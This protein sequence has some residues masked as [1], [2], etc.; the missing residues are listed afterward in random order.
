MIGGPGNRNWS[1]LNQFFGGPKSVRTAFQGSHLVEKTRPKTRGGGKALGFLS[2]G[3]AL[4]RG[5]TRARNDTITSVY[6]GGRSI[7]KEEDSSAGYKKREIIHHGVGN[8]G[9]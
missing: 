8:N 4:F 5:K 6:S 7:Q 1:A 9:D 3:W 2:R